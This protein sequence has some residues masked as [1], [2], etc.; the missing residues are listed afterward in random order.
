MISVK[1]NSEFDINVEANEYQ[2]KVIYHLHNLAIYKSDLLSDKG[3]VDEFS[4]HVTLDDYN[5]QFWKTFSTQIVPEIHPNGAVPKIVNN[6]RTGKNII[7]FRAKSVIP[8][9]KHLTNNGGQ[10]YYQ[11]AEALIKHAHLAMKNLEKNGLGIVNFDVNDFIVIN[12]EYFLFINSEKVLFFNEDSDTGKSFMIN[13]PIEKG[14]FSSP[15]LVNISSL[16]FKLPL[17]C[18]LFSL[19]SFVGT[20]ITSTHLN[21]E[22][23]DDISSHSKNVEKFLLEILDTKLYWCL[24]KCLNKDPIKRVFLLIH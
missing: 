12:D 15:E 7:T 1:N 4:I 9:N 3:N 22:H 17:Q 11:N 2:G 18:G 6:V 10:L 5:K 13:E 24:K 8:L 21:I 16:P 20:M 23:D 14:T 19:C